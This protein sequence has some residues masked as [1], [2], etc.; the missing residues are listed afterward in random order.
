MTL[1]EVDYVLMNLLSIKANDVEEIYSSNENSEKVF[2]VK[3]K[4]P[5]T[6][7]CPTCGCLRSVSKGF[8]KKE[9]LLSNEAFNGTRVI[10]EI[11]RLKCPDCNTSYSLGNYLCPSGH[12]V[13][14]EVIVKIMDLLKNPEI[15]FASCARLVGVSEPTVTRI[16][17]RHCHITRSVFPEAL[18][19]DEVYTKLN[20][21]KNNSSQM[22]KYSYLFYDF[23][24]H[25]LVDVQPSRTKAYLHHYFSMIP[26]NER[27]GVKYVVIDMYRNYRDLAHI[28]F[29]KAVICVD[30]FHVIQHLNNSLNQLRIRIMKRYESNTDSQEYYLL[31]L[32]NRLLFS[33]DI[34]PNHLG[35]FNKKMNQIMNYYQLR[36]ALLDIDPDLRKAYLLKEEYTLF[37][38][39]CDFEHA[40]EH[41]N[42]L[43]EKF[44]K[45]D[46]PEYREF[47][48]MVLEWK[49]YIVNSFIT[50]KGRRLNNGVAESINARVKLLLYNT[51]GIRNSSR[52]RKRIMYA[53]NKN[54]FSIK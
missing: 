20:D 50:Y 38:S 37:N 11:P 48:S 34:D 2:I 45:A 30:S 46:I 24:N 49:P 36:E 23:Y 39:T 13:S 8:Y 3:L 10:L 35:R 5:K 6:R 32:W 18:C 27:L 52:R 17:D 16:F 43:L 33:N 12:R 31:K 28:Y 47:T 29:K 7:I 40:E 19:I 9:M 1:N 15:T 4:K 26:V 21:F 14:Y 51:R 41:L 53:V 25:T 22:S 54:G 44:F 42:A